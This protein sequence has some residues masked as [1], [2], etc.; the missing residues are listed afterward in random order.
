M[1]QVLAGKPA[2]RAGLLAGDSIAAIDGHAVRGWGEVVTVIEASPGRVVRFEVER[3]GA[4]QA[5][6]ITP[7]SVSEVDR[8]TKATR[9]IGR[10][11]AAVR[12]DPNARRVPLGDALTAGWTATWEI[13]RAVV[14]VLRDLLIGRASPRELGGIIQ[15]ASES[16]EAAKVGFDMLLV[17]LAQ[18]SVNLAVFNLLP[19]PILDGGQIVLNVA[20]AARGRAFSDRTRQ[21]IAYVGLATIAI[22]VV[23][24]LVNDVARRWL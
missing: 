14:T 12:P 10:I 22:L 7:D 4:R 20:E 18:I 15:I 3:A 5:L 6:V 17:F 21:V 16:S 1:Q 9:V 8:G 19:I 13:A 23:F 24:A 11:G 2:K